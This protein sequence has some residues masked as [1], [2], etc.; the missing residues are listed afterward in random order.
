V[1]GAIDLLSG[2]DSRSVVAIAAEVGPDEGA[3]VYCARTAAPARGRSSR[4]ASSRGRY[5]W[6]RPQHPCAGTRCRPGA[7]SDLG[8]PTSCS[9]WTA[10][11]RFRPVAHGSGAPIR[12]TPLTGAAERPRHVPPRPWGSQGPV[13]VG[14]ASP[15]RRDLPLA[16]RRCQCATPL[17]WREPA[18]SSHST[19]RAP[20]LGTTS[21][22]ICHDAYDYSVPLEAG[23]WPPPRHAPRP[24]AERRLQGL[25]GAL[26]GVAPG[27]PGARAR[28]RVADPDRHLGDTG[29]AIAHAFLGCPGIHAVVLFPIHEVSDRQRRQM[30]T[31]GG[32]V[33]TLALDS[34]FRLQALVKEAFSTRP[35]RPEPHFRQLDQ[36]RPPAAAVGV[37]HPRRA[38]LADVAG[39][40]RWS[41][42][43]PRATSAT[44]WVACSP[45]ARAAGGALRGRHHAND[46]VPAP[47]RPAATRRSSPRQVHLQRHERGPPSNLARGRRALRRPPRRGLAR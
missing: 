38:K 45:C 8:H 14:A 1:A 2:T 40:S 16:P 9:D 21:P 3:S 46:E 25:R 20:S 28:P 11:T 17:S 36:H 6:Q 13:E 33:R 34:K 27:R 30:T 32:N 26:H 7:R 47:R 5:A 15:M 18:G 4:S 43:S 39:A 35:D 29:S 12:T 37:L 31:L 19:P 41:S 22:A 44:S 10:A 24:G 23:R 42:A